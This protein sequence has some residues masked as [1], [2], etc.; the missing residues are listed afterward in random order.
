MMDM[1]MGRVLRIPEGFQWDSHLQ[2]MTV[3]VIEIQCI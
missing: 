1:S 3:E 2:N